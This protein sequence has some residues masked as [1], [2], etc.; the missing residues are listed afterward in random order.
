MGERNPEAI[1]GVGVEPV[2]EHAKAM[3]AI[4]PRHLP[5]MA[6]LQLAL[7]EAGEE[8]V[9]W[10]ALTEGQNEEILRQVPRRKRGEMMHHLAFLRNMSCVGSIHPEYEEQREWLRSR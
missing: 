4:A 2:A 9:E 7:D 1:S 3:R 5:N 6:L 8:D 10:H